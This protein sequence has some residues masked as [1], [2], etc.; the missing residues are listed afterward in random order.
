MRVFRFALTACAASLLYAAPARDP[1]L[2]KAQATLER[3]P[4]RF[5]A[6]LGQWI[7]TVRYAARA[8]GYSLLLTGVGPT[9]AVGGSQRVDISLMGSNPAPE[10]QPLE[11]L[12]VRTSYFVGAQDR[13]R[14]DVPAYSRV[15]YR[16]VYPGI[17][18][19]YY[20]SQE[21]LEYDFTV[22][23]GADPSAIRLRFQGADRVSITPE[24]DLLLEAAGRRIVQKL[25]LLYQE[26]AG[27]AARREIPGRYAMLGDNLI[28]FAV[29]RYDAAR[30][31]VID[32]YLVYSTYIGGSGTDEIDAIKTDSHGYLY[33][34]G[35]TTTSD[36]VV[37]LGAWSSANTGATGTADV[38][39][40]VLDTTAPDPFPLRYLS[41][42]GGSADDLPSGIDVDSNYHLYITGFTKSIDYP[43]FG[44]AVQTA[45]LSPLGA[46]SATAFVTELDLLGGG[47]PYSTY[48]GGT[49][50]TYGNAIA[51]DQN[52]LMDIIGTTIAS[53]LPVTDS[54]YAAV[55]YGPQD[56]FLC[57]LD[58]NAT[59]PAYSSYMGGELVDSGVAIAIGADGLAY[60]TGTTNSTQ[61]PLAGNSYRSTLQGQED[62]IIGVMDF[63]QSGVD[64]LVYSTYFGG[65]DSDVVRQLKFDNSGHVL[66]TGYTLSVDFPITYD[67]CQG[68]TGGNGDAFVSVVN[69]WQRSAFLV[70]STFL[71]GGQ[72]DVAYDVIPD[73]TGSLLVTGYTLSP[74]FPITYDAPQPQFGGGTEVFVAKIQPGTPGLA[75]LEFSTYLGTTGIHIAK[76]IAVASNGT[77]YVAGFTN[78]GLP[79]VGASALLY[80]G[81]TR[82]G[83]FLLLTQ[84]AAQPVSSV[85]NHASPPRPAG[86]KLGS[87]FR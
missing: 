64:S 36:L 50:P 4:L 39:I 55:L 48:F 84:L 57:Q 82:D 8:P 83:F 23:P 5:E 15:L 31:L 63:T 37:T 38:L 12:S 68:V 40:V 10:I 6:N 76:G 46:S 73:A 54:A 69:P 52:G 72:S 7:P 14:S 30:P 25:P 80:G 53:D 66:L 34:V 61:F 70:Y 22:A 77:V 75:G 49:N 18:V 11:R 81:G 9:I 19:V 29:G 41:Y 13:W 74:D 65:S 16:Q 1:G 20:G 78:L 33:M 32:P 43:I 28:G 87:P 62:I 67:A 79:S 24:G 47:L 59:E 85:R 42:L 45:P 35:Y 51:V 21:R 56:M 2:L 58:P 44:N 26:G 3:L 27:G 71:G 17:D 86:E 60:F